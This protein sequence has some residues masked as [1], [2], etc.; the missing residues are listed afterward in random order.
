MAFWSAQTLKQRVTAEGIIHPYDEALVER[1]NY[2]L[3][4]GRQAYVSP[5]GIALD[6]QSRT[7]TDLTQVNCPI[8]PGQF[9]FILTKEKICVPFDAIGFI[10]LRAKYKFRGLVNVSGFHVDPGWN[11]NIIFAVFNA[12]SETFIVEENEK[13]FQIWF[14][15][16][17][18]PM[19]DLKHK[20]TLNGKIGSQII[21]GVGDGHVSLFGLSEAVKKVQTDHQTLMKENGII[22]TTA[23]LMLQAIIGGLIVGGILKFINFDKGKPSDSVP[24][25]MIESP[26]PSAIKAPAIVPQNSGEDELSDDRKNQ[27]VTPQDRR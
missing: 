27:D 10:S 18:E 16:L 7:P 23:R 2:P 15:S 12:G 9:G 8:P 21:S 1:A 11:D 5:I 17:D 25:V 19:T 13:L 20:S 14:A 24:Q 22:R 26:S 6:P 3:H 4:V